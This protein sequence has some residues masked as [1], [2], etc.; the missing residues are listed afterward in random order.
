MNQSLESSGVTSLLNELKLVAGADLDAIIRLAVAVQLRR[1]EGEP[2]EAVEITRT[3]AL[4]AIG[5]TN[6]A[7]RAEFG[8]AGL[9]WS[10][11]ES[12]ARVT[13]LPS[14]A[15][16]A[17]GAVPHKHLERALR[18]F[19][20]SRPDRS[21][22]GA[23]EL[24]LAILYSI[25]TDPTSGHLPARLK[26]CGLNLAEAK[27]RIEKLP[28]SARIEF[29]LHEFLQHNLAVT[30]V[31]SDAED[32]VI[33]ELQEKETISWGI[34]PALDEG[35]FVLMYIPGQLTPRFSMSGP[36]FLR[37]YRVAGP[38]RPTDSKE[39]WSHDVDLKRH[40]PL[41]PP[42]TVD[43]LREDEVL[44][45][46]HLLKTKFRN[47]GREEKPVGKGEQSALGNMIVSRIG[48]PPI[49]PEVLRSAAS[50]GDEPATRDLLGRQDLVESLAAMLDHPRQGTPF[51]I[52]LLGDWGS[53]KTTVMKLLERELVGLP[54]NHGAD[55]PVMRRHKFVCAWFNAWQYEKTG[56]LAAGLAQETVKALVG[57]H[58]PLDRFWLRI[59]FAWRKYRWQF[60][61]TLASLLVRTIVVIAAA[62]LA[63]APKAVGLG[64]VFDNV[65]GRLLSGTF[66]LGFGAFTVRLFMHA[67]ELWNHPT[68]DRMT[69]YLKLPDYAKHLGMIPVLHE[70][71]KTLCELR[72]I[73]PVDA[74]KTS[75]SGAQ[76][77]TANVTPRRLVVFVDDLDRCAPQA[78][79][80]T[81][82]A[83]RLVMV[84]PEVVLI[85]G[86]DARIAFRAVGTHYRALADDH[87]SP[88]DI[89]RDFLGKIIQ[90]P[91]R[92][93]RPNNLKEFVQR[94]FASSGEYERSSTANEPQT[95][96]MTATPSIPAPGNSTD[97]D[98]SSPTPGTGKQTRSSEQAGTAPSEAS[99]GDHAA[100]IAVRNELDRDME[101]SEAE[102]EQFETLA[103]LFD[104]CNPRKLLRLRNSYRLLKLLDLQWVYRVPEHERFAPPLLMASLFWQE[105]LHACSPTVREE[106]EKAVDGANKAARK[107]SDARA[108]EI[109]G[110]FRTTLQDNPDWRDSFKNAV[111]FVRRLVLPR[112]DTWVSAVSHPEPTKTS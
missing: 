25:D 90:L 93:G 49:A 100:R 62:I 112:G 27:S 6:S 15:E 95:T 58:G 52:G 59:R 79:V 107:V 66:A 55:R 104:I 18:Q 43:E 82:D 97:E 61:G 105:F 51:T 10:Q 89:A 41:D 92:L 98:P 21:V 4:I 48:S 111:D 14:P 11:L 72:G 70:H 91:I 88:Q 96:G 39:I 68:A 38:T 80:D 67:R 7:M 69:A 76:G 54:E 75:N 86:I 20:E 30:T 87:A 56:D 63:L 44:G 102:S 71:I 33:S 16:T 13:E 85:V 42:I 81:F 45:N 83:I 77:S 99:P 84:I 78:I 57:E 94:L 47:A 24:A 9:E 106:C 31:A 65:V 110:R 74:A 23:V 36:G 29:D 73:R 64:T 5:E 1:V 34:G 26:D 32:D 19:A 60:V 103:E 101:H 28:P 2:P 8:A 50:I 40:L 46:W 22:I 109:V 17:K 53:G 35:D 108:D 37:L 3:V 12:A